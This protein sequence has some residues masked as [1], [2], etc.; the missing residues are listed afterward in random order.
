MV[1]DII[2]LDL[3]L[4]GRMDYCGEYFHL[5][6]FHYLF[7]LLKYFICVFLFWRVTWIGRYDCVSSGRFPVHD[8]LQCFNI[9]RYVDTKNIN[10]TVL[11]VFLWE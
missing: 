5:L 6:K 11:F 7:C 1:F 8:E 2:I 3:L 4:W 10:A 9:S